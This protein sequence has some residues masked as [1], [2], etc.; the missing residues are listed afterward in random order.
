MN[1]TGTLV[2][3]SSISQEGSV[4]WAQIHLRSKQFIDIQKYFKKWLFI[5]SYFSL[6]LKVIFMSIL[7]YCKQHSGA[8]S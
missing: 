5:R 1:S 8:A 4:S 6:F 7:L 2:K 3:D